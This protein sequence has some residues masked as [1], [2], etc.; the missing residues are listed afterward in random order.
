MS[1]GEHTI[2]LN[3]LI[4][5]QLINLNLDNGEMIVQNDNK[6][7]YMKFIYDCYPLHDINGIDSFSQNPSIA[8]IDIERSDC[9]MS[10][11]VITFK[12][13]CKP[14]SIFPVYEQL[15]GTATVTIWFYNL[16]VKEEIIEV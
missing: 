13:L 14:Y 5:C 6:Q 9:I 8:C 12:G 4:G 11:M 7:Y 15:L 1:K 10:K 3:E 16:Q 2:D